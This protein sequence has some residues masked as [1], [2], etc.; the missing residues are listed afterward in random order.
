MT[1]ASPHQAAI[2]NP[3]QAIA[4]PVVF[5]DD[6]VTGGKGTTIAHKFAT[7]AD[8]AE[9]LQTVDNSGTVVVTD[10]APGGVITLNPGTGAADFISLQ[11]NG[12][13]FALAAGKQLVFE[14]RFKLDDADDAKWYVGLASTD[15]TGTVAGPILDGTNDSIGFRNTEGNT[16]N[17]FMLCEDDT[18]ETSTDTTKDLANDTYVILRFEAFGTDRVEF[19]VDGE[20]VGVVKTNLPDSGAA[21]TPTIEISSTTGTTATTMM[22]DYIFVQQ[23]RIART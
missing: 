21:L 19:F 22:V 10:A 17:I 23:D 11:L 8:A 16:Y 18:T 15:V 13:A 6:F 5:F 4:L 20:R 14:I 3:G 9:W 7:T 12:E 2:R 1:Y